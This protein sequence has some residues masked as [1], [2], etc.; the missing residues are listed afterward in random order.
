MR[1][2]EECVCRGIWGGGGGGREGVGRGGG[3]VGRDGPL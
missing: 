1:K 2:E 3:E